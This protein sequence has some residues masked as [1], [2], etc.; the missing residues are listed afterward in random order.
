MTE[1]A[2]KDRLLCFPFSLSLS[3]MFV[4]PRCLA[5]P[6]PP[7]LHR[8]QVSLPLA[9]H[10]VDQHPVW[11]YNNQGSARRIFRGT[12]EPG[13]TSSPDPQSMT[14]SC[15]PPE[16]SVVLRSAGGLGGRCV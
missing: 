10:M 7:P 11:W 3:Y 9:S 13:A 1:K 16:G 12:L 15:P 6:T 2:I 4:P 8:R 14:E 5:N